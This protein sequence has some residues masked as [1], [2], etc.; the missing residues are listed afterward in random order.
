M[1]VCVCVCVLC[2]RVCIFR[3]WQ[4]LAIMEEGE[5]VGEGKE[6]VIIHF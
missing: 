2:V 4:L 3:G 6:R 5:S 1:C